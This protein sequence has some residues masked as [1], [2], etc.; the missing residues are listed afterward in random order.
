M[1]LN[2]KEDTDSARGSW[3]R[4]ENRGHGSH[5]PRNKVVLSH[6]ATKDLMLLKDLRNSMHQWPIWSTVRQPTMTVHADA[7]LSAYGDTLRKGDYGSENR[8]TA[9]PRSIGK[10]R[11]E[12]IDD[13]GSYR[14]ISEELRGYFEKRGPR[15]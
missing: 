13:D 14:R 7:S 8:A 15:T 1:S 4:S 6:P 5:G 3:I 10:D 12:T 11:T 9:K 2:G